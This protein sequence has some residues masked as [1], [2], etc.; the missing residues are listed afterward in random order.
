MSTGSPL[1]Y[2]GYGDVPD[3]APDLLCLQVSTR[4]VKM[5]D[6]AGPLAT[7]MS[8]TD[9]P[10]LGERYQ[11]RMIL[12][13][14]GYDDDPR[15]LFLIPAVVEWFR[16]LASHWNAWLYF[17]N[18]ADCRG[19]VALLM[20]LRSG[21]GQLE[22]VELDKE[23]AYLTDGLLAYGEHANLPAPLLECILNTALSSLFQ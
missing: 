12:A 14:D 19:Q 16:A 6:I 21:K 3:E 9:N 20:Q 2:H 22:G 11:G 1:S 4:E 18:V 8:L 7:L 15:P 23:L 17:I 13:F 10:G 5:M